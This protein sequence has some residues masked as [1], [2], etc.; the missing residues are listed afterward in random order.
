M[1][2]P[3]MTHKKVRRISFMKT[4]SKWGELTGCATNAKATGVPVQA[5]DRDRHR[6]K[7]DNGLSV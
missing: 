3:K 1:E 5:L 4:S 2:K 7:G 6:T